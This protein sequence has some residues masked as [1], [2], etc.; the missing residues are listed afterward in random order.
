MKFIKNNFKKSLEVTLC[1]YIGVSVVL[2]ILYNIYLNEHLVNYKSYYVDEPFYTINNLIVLIFE[3]VSKL[4]NDISLF[5][6]IV[7]YTT[8]FNTKMFELIISIPYLS[9]LF[10][11]LDW[12]IMYVLFIVILAFITLKKVF[13][14]TIKISF[15]IAAIYV[16]YSMF[17]QYTLSTKYNDVEYISNERFS[18]CE[19]IEVSV[20]KVVDGDTIK[21]NYQGSEETVRLLYIDTPEATK[22]VEEYGYEATN[23]LKAVIMRADTV[24]IEF[25]GNT[26]DKYGRLLAWVWVDDVLAQEILTKNGLVEDFYDYGNYKYEDEIIAAMK[27]AQDNKIKIHKN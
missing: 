4:L 1:I 21:I 22:E 17:Y 16:L 13:S 9:Y 20:N 24:Y 14:F 7:S 3:A 10:K 18:E 6:T 26:R 8:L 15:V 23:M 11:S 2:H 25:D 5:E 27:Y 19:C 12:T